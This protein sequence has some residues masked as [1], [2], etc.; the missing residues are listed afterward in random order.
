MSL[1]FQLL[2]LDFSNCHHFQLEIPIKVKRPGAKWKETLHLAVSIMWISIIHSHN[3]VFENNS[4]NYIFKIFI[5]YLL[6]MYS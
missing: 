2:C 1:F 3:M 6:N 4:L 5:K